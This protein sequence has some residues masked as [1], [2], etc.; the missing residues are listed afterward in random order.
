VDHD[1]QGNEGAVVSFDVRDC[2]LP[3]AERP[4]RLAEF[5]ELFAGAL[6]RVERVAPTHL[7]LRLAGD[8]GLAADV[9][10][11]TERE[12]RCCSFFT[13]TVTA[14]PGGTAVTLDVEVPDRHTDVLDTLAGRAVATAG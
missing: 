6:R 10:D 11:L 7:R 12:S 9:T 4:G 2:T 1:K 14:D 13:F 5:D 8:A 3:A